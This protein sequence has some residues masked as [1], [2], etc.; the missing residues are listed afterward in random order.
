MGRMSWRLGLRA[1]LAIARGSVAFAV[2]AGGRGRKGDSG[3]VGRCH[4]DDG[5]GEAPDGAGGDVRLA[6]GDGCGDGGRVSGRDGGRAHRAGGAGDVC[7]VCEGGLDGGVG[8]VLGD[9]NRRGS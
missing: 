1:L 2:L 6:A 3:A 4:C 9:V 8:Y 5:C 7:C